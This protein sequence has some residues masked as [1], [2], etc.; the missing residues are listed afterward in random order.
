MLNVPILVAENGK[1]G[2]GALIAIAGS[3]QY[4]QR[5]NGTENANRVLMKFLKSVKC[6]TVDLPKKWLDLAN[7][8]TIDEFKEVLK[9]LEQNYQY[10]K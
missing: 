9:I 1:K 6:K 7:F 8:N 10:E 2:N 4:L 3:M 5:Q